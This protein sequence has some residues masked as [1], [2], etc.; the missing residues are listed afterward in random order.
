MS[1]IQD[2][3]QRVSEQP[4]YQLKLWMGGEAWQK[5]LEVAE[6]LTVTIRGRL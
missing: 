3:V 2:K 6:E 4:V 1:E 5:T